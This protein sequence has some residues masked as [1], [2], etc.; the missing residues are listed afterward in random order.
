[1][2]T[3]TP[4]S[5]PSPPAASATSNPL[6]GISGPAMKIA[7]VAALFLLMLVPLY[8]V[9]GVISERRERQAD[10][11]KEFT[12]SWGPSQTVL[13]PILVVPFR[14]SDGTERYLHIAPSKLAVGAQ[15][16]PEMRRRGIF[17]ALVY[18]ATVDFKG[19]FQIPRELPSGYG[20]EPLDWPNAVVLLR[21]TDLRAL[22]STAQLAWGDRSLPWEACG[23][24]GVVTCE[25]DRFV[26]A[27]LGLAAAPAADIAIAFATRIELSGTQALCFTPIGRDVDLTLTA[28]W[29]DA[30]FS[31]PPLP[32]TKWTDGGFSASWHVASNVATGPWMWSSSAAIDSEINHR[33]CIGV[34]LHEAVPT[35]QM[36]ERTTKY[37]LLFLALSFLTYFLFEATSGARIHIIQYGLLGLSIS[38]FALL[39]IS[40]AEPLGFE[41]GYGIASML[42]LLQASLYTAAVVRRP[43]QAAT[44]AG[45]LAALFGF[46]YVVLSL[47]SYALLVG[48]VALFSALSVT[49]VVTRHIDWSKGQ[50][51]RLANGRIGA[52]DAPA[53]S[54]S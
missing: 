34:D 19:G 42:V 27:R 2:E 20:G 21:A 29:R 4:D 35:Y 52:A 51:G 22:P 48:A 8:L 9:S 1:M 53:N 10:V 6:E 12:A 49:M 3:A 50:W 16:A 26:V 36:V 25:H 44:F 15:L 33:G 38:L 39:L 32:T 37:G 30:S 5:P 28:P 18:G 41:A 11:L 7:L 46:L 31:G 43:R 17:H 54:G 14:G 24:D 13:G 47:E 45:I 23:D 40:F